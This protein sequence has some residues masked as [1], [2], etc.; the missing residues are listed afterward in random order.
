MSFGEVYQGLV[1][2]VI[3]GAE[4]NWPSYE[5]TRHFEAAQ[6]YSLSRHVM[7][8]EALVMSKRSWDRSRRMTRTCS[9]RPL[10]TACP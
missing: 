4:N 5:A 2:G 7:A 1:Q 10:V 8:P 6:Y 9:G 3:D